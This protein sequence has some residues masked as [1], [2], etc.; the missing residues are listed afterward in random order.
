MGRESFRVSAPGKL[1]LLGE[2]AVLHGRKA[3]VGAVNQRIAVTCKARKDSKIHLI[4]A[5]GEYSTWLDNI[6]I[7][8]AF[9]F[10]LTALLQE[11]EH[12][13]CGLDMKIEADF[14]ADL[15]LGSSAAVT[16]AAMG[17][18]FTL[19][20]RKLDADKVFAAAMQT[21]QTVQGAGS[22]ADLAASVYGGIL[23]Y[24]KEPQSVRKVESSF[25]LTVINSGS[26]LATAQV[27]GMVEEKYNRHQELFSGIYDL[28]DKSVNA[29][30]E[31]IERADYK[32]L[33]EVFNVN[34]GLMDAIGVSNYLL[35]G[36]NYRLRTEPGITGSK[37]SG[38]GLGD[39]VIGVGK[40]TGAGLP[41]QTLPLEFSETGLCIDQG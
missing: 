12:L 27:I 6:E 14:S 21:I 11:Q 31:A 26:K 41:W 3:L 30:V 32:Y 7:I 9:R 35:A 28:M 17:A 25:P 18:L 29:A 13:S 40:L 39:C 5:L 38:S 20:R 2:H 36:I 1:M 34:Q 23:C 8:P 16:A 37:I 15:G 22:G 19:S 33:G 24:Q 10:V 4:S